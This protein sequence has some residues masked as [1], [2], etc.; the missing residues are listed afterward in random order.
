M[1]Q[2]MNLNEL[3][4][5]PGMTYSGRQTFDAIVDEASS[6]SRAALVRLVDR[7]KDVLEEE[8]IVVSGEGAYADDW[9]LIRSCRADFYVPLVISTLA[10]LGAGVFGTLACHASSPVPKLLAFTLPLALVAML[11]F[12]LS[13][14]GYLT[15]GFSTC[16]DEQ[17]PIS[18][19]RRRAT[20]AWIVGEKAI[21]VA[22]GVVNGKR[23]EVKTVFYDSIGTVD[24]E[25][26]ANGREAIVIR[27]RDG[28]LVAE[29]DA[30]TISA[31][32]NPSAISRI[33]TSRLRA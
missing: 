32:D 19:I 11:P 20:L 6:L 22:T 29:I 15:K 24:V 33:I 7:Q 27:G 12:L 3:G 26:N 16:S 4:P 1:D 28:A 31:S 21:Y 18:T 5:F 13:S 17:S 25:E 14:F 10:A 30:P 23:P 2:P 9:R 8:N